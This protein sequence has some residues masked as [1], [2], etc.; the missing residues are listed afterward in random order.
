MLNLNNVQINMIKEMQYDQYASNTRAITQFTSV[1]TKYGADPQAVADKMYEN[2][3]PKN[4]VFK[5]KEAEEHARV[6][7]ELEQH[8]K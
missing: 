8:E 1:C 7:A 2:Y 4:D 6:K 5:R 3:K